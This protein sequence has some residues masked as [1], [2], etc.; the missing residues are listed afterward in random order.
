[1]VVVE[2][3]M[4]EMEWKVRRLFVR[5][6]VAVLFAGLLGQVNCAGQSE[7]KGP[8]CLDLCEK[9]MKDCPE[10]P[11]VD[12]ESQCLYEDARAQRTGCQDEVDA[13]A[14]CSKSLD[15]IC[16]TPTDCKPEVD[17]FWV[18]VNAYC[19]KHPTSQYCP[20]PKEG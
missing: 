10:L 19:A 14:S 4:V 16:T 12:C 3:K 6:P 5:L 13:V 17:R 1:V 11:R 7:E 2:G 8:H 20:M 18:C 15:N 9:G